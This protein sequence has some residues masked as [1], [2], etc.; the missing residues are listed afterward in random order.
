VED[1]ELR[2]YVNGIR[3]SSV[4]T[5]YCMKS[6]AQWYGCFQVSFS[7]SR[8]KI[9]VDSPASAPEIGAA[10][11]E[12]AAPNPQDQHADDMETETLT[13]EL[14]NILDG[15]EDVSI[16]I[17][18][19]EDD[20][21]LIAVSVGF[22]HLT[23]YAAEDIVGRNC[24][25][26][27]TGSEMEPADRAGIRTALATG[28]RFT[29]VIPN[30]RKDLSPFLNLL[31]LRTLEVG[32]Q[33]LSGAPVRLVVGIQGE[34]DAGRNSAHWRAELPMLTARVR[35]KIRQRL[36][37]RTRIL[38]TD[39]GATVT[40]H[41]EPFW[42]DDTEQPQFNSPEPLPSP[43]VLL[44]APGSTTPIMRNGESPNPEL[45]LQ[46]NPFS[47]GVVA[48]RPV[49]WTP[50]AVGAFLQHLD[51]SMYIDIFA[52]ERVDGEVLLDL[53]PESCADLGVK[54]HHQK[55]LLRA[56]DKLRG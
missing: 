31:D 29:T 42:V 38:A 2:R 12:V 54:K 44:P 16:T 33:R 18:S 9:V 32:T 40:P 10:T 35:E 39:S 48:T 27:N 6:D 14:K 11:Y 13:V 19:A 49:A 26:L 21:P 52:A 55:K 51:L 34:V 25:F 23:G 8:A 7:V 22:E 15:V 36:R 37:E 30:L 28:A 3:V 45:H 46:T 20:F 24:R 4:R 41:P 1:M 53:D 5:G 43:A 56:I 50:E 17:A 47:P